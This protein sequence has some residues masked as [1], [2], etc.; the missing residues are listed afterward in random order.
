M[1]V[2]KKKAL[3]KCIEPKT[4]REQSKQANITIIK[5]SRSKRI[6]AFNLNHPQMGIRAPH[7]PIP[8][9]KTERY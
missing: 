1:A 6:K 5:V 7:P 8:D 3:K 2:H 4:K 9:P